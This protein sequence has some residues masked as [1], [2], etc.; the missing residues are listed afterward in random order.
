[1]ANGKSRSESTSC[2][3]GSPPSE[4]L[5]RQG[6]VI[7]DNVIPEDI[8]D[9]DSNT[10]EEDNKDNHKT[11]KKSGRGSD[12]AAGPASTPCPNSRTAFMGMPRQEQVNYR[13]VTWNSILATKIS[14]GCHSPYPL[15]IF[16]C[17]LKNQV[18]IKF[19]E[20]DF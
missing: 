1:V 3:I 16:T 10:L 14:A 15:S 6:L 20:L 19:A 7:F 11:V 12:H 4:I 9:L 2:Q 13:T 17:F 18:G 5:E 8:H